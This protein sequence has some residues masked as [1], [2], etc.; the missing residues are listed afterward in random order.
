MEIDR[1]DDTTSVDYRKYK[2]RVWLKPYVVYTDSNGLTYAIYKDSNSVTFDDT[3]KK[4]NQNGD[5]PPDFQQTITLQQTWHDIFDRILFG[6]TQATDS[7][8]TQTVIIR[9]FTIDFKNKN[10]F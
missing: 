10:D 8:N 3:S 4:F 7:T 9:N 5:Y 6:W 1:V 2:M